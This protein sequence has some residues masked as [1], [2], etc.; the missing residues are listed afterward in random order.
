[1]HGRGN[2]SRMPCHSCGLQ[3]LRTASATPDHTTLLLAQL[4]HVAGFRQLMANKPPSAMAARAQ[5]LDQEYNEAG[6]LRRAQEAVIAA[7]PGCMQTTDFHQ[8]VTART[9]RV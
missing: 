6:E 5:Q 4:A 9:Q 2:K 7:T 3:P 1:M 8:H